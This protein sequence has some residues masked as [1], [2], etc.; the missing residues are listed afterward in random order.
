MVDS[1][2]SSID[3][4]APN[5]QGIMTF[6]FTSPSLIDS[7]EYIFYYDDDPYY[8]SVRSDISYEYAVEDGDFM[9][10]ATNNGKDDISYPYLYV[11]FMDKDD[12]VL[13][14]DW[15]GFYSDEGTLKAG[16]SVTNK[17]WGTSTYDHV[18]IFIS[19]VKY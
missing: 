12:K 19:A 9:L 13:A 2:N 6:Y 16:E 10:T 4:L 15:T 17:M 7:V 14:Y 8:H 18:L 1:S 5:D 11:L 3:A